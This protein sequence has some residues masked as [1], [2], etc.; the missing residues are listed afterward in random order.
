LAHQAGYQVT[1]IN[2][3][4]DR[5]AKTVHDKIRNSLESRALTSLGALSGNKPTCVVIDEIDGAGGGD[6]V[7]FPQR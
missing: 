2:A 5:T 6:A 7:S 4:D 1:E 3:S